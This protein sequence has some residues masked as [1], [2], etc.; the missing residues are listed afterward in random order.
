MSNVQTLRFLASF[1]HQLYTFQFLRKG[2]PAGY[3][4]T[5]AADL[6]RTL[7]QFENLQEKG[8]EIFF[9]VNE[10]DGI[11]YPGN[12]I[13]RSQEN[14]RNLSACFIDT[15]SAPWSKVKSFLEEKK[16]TP[17]YVVETSPGKF[18]VYFLLNPI[19]ANV[20]NVRKWQS[21]QAVLASVKGSDTSMTDYA[22]VLRVPGFLHLKNPQKPHKI[23]IKYEQ[24]NLLHDLDHLLKVLNVTEEAS[25]EL[26]KPYELKTEPVGEGERHNE[27]T[28][29]LGKLLNLGVDPRSAAWS[30][31]KYAQ[32]V[33]TDWQD[34]QPGGSRYSEVTA[35]VDWKLKDLDKEKKAAQIQ[36]VESLSEENSKPTFD[37]P[38]E[39]YFKAPGLVGEITQEINSAVLYQ[40]PSFAFATAISVLG[41]LK[42]KHRSSLRHAPSNYFLCLAPT[43]T[44]KN[45][46]QIIL[47]NTLSK[48]GLGSLLSSAIRSSQ[49]ILNHLDKN[50]SNGVIS[51]DEAEGFFHSLDDKYAQH[52]TRQCRALLLELYSSCNFAHK[53]FGKTGNKKEKEIVLSYP[54]LNLLAYGA[55]HTVEKAFNKKSV[56][57]GLLQ[58]FIVLTHRKERSRNRSA[59]DLPYLNGNLLEHLKKLAWNESRSLEEE[60]AALEQAEVA[61]SSEK[62]AE[63][64]KEL[65]KRL[66][67]LKSQA[68]ER[69]V[70]R[71]TPAAASIYYEYSDSLD[72]KINAEA[73]KGT[74]L[75]GIYTRAAEQIGRLA[76]AIADTEID[77]PL[78]EYL[79]TFIDSRIN[80]LYALVD[81]KLIEESVQKD[82]APLL[83]FI[84][85]RI[86]AS[87]GSEV[88]YA[89]IARHYV[90]R[91]PALLKELLQH[92]VETEQLTEIISKG[93]GRPGKKYKLNQV[94]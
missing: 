36:I 71:F 47:S 87:N 7:S 14:V 83:R 1:S 30:F 35:F 53:A 43:G 37:L 21:V 4:L 61:E 52:Y 39:F 85:E 69:K 51:L 80:A 91:K 54:R 33:F 79:I 90:I 63:I 28:A 9:M 15:D 73:R 57:D 18:H 22:K 55:L 72:K 27:M 3:E 17:S 92:L 94:L 20:K 74:D 86:A 93:S 49:G 44:G 31:E 32:S 75:E 67:K 24:K 56:A 59:R 40:I 41:S 11:I 23:S 2:K 82:S 16:L 77:K 13:P 5:E 60:L 42:S 65:L 62:T 45:D 88:G 26:H 68:K 50:D 66:E 58:R 19:E 8:I 78:I 25:K 38:D 81:E 29:Y 48:L 76:V 6:S 12:K 10:G 89:D 64:R 34:W 84:A 70:I 46:P